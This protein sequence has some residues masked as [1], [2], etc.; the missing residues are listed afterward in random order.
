MVDSGI[1]PWLFN[2]EPYEGESLSHF[3]GRV[4]SRNHLTASGLGQLA[5]IGAVVARWERFHLNPYPTQAQFEALGKLLG[6]SSER[7]WTMLPPQGEGMKCEPIRLCGACYKES[8]CHRI[9]WQ[10]KSRWKCDLHNLKLLAKC[11]NCEARFKIPALWEDGRCNRCRMSFG[12]MA[13][14]ERL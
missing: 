14:L 2:V 12:E 8:P 7:F 3:L 11:S 1:Q 6:I 10:F 13:T 4:R 5:G 9:E